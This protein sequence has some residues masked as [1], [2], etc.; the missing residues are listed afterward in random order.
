MD[1]LRQEDF[2]LKNKTASRRKADMAVLIHSLFPSQTSQL[3]PQQ[4]AL[5]PR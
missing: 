5:K 3:H 4:N 1:Y 2:S